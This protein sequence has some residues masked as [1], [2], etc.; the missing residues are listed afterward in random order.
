[1][2]EE[3]SGG[4]HSIDNHQHHQ[5]HH[6]RHRYSTG[7]QIQFLR[8]QRVGGLHISELHHERHNNQKKQ[9]KPNQNQQPLKQEVKHHGSF[10]CLR[11]GFLDLQVGIFILFHLLLLV[12]LDK[13]SDDG[14]VYD[15][16]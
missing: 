2:R 16:K 4:I 1:M 6:H 14:D 8:N 15:D 7:Q 10:M 11:L 9:H 5:S 13:L 12:A 3:P